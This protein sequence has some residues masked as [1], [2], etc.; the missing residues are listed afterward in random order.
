ML[1]L[2]LDNLLTLPASFLRHTPELPSS[3]LPENENAN[4]YDPIPFLEGAL[5]NLED[6]WQLDDALPTSEDIPLA[7]QAGAAASATSTARRLQTTV[8]D[9]SDDEETSTG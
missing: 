3:P 1:R 9:A 2:D 6:D 8:E 5:V 4:E 7:T